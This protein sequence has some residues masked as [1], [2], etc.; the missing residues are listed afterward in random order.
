MKALTIHGA[1][2]I[3]WGDREVPTPGAGQVRIRVAYVGI[4]GSSRRMLAVPSLI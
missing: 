3:R 2:D 4:C 1:E